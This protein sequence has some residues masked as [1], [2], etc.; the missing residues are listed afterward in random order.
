MV[1]SKQLEEEIKEVV[2]LQAN[3]TD[4]QRALIEF[5]RDGPGSVQQAGHWLKFAQEVSIRG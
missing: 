4:E 2:D 1:G 3:L 5:M